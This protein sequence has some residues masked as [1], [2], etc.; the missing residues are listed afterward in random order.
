MPVCGGGP[1]GVVDEKRPPVA[2]DEAGVAFPNNPPPLLLAVEVSVLLGVCEGVPKGD[3][4]FPN[5]EVPAP[6]RDGPD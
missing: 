5:E 1:A 3:G 2:D 6:N 4:L